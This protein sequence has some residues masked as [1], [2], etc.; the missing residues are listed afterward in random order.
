MHYYVY[1]HSRQT[2][3]TP[4]YVGMGSYGRAYE[5]SGSRRNFIWHRINKKHGT[6][7]D[8][9]QRDMSRN[10]ALLLEMWL[11]AKFR[12]EGFRLANMTMGGEGTLGHIPSSRVPVCCSDKNNDIMCFGHAGE[13]ASYLRELGYKNVFRSNISSSASGYKR[14]AYDRVWWVD[15]DVT[16]TYT[17]K[18]ELIA[19]SHGKKIYNS[20]GIEFSR[21]SEAISWLKTVGIANPGQSSISK[22]AINEGVAYGYSWSY[23]G[24]PKKPALVGRKVGANASRL[25]K[26]IPVVS[27]RGEMFLSAADAARSMRDNG[28][29]NAGQGNISRAIAQPNR[30]AYGRK[31]FKA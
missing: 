16:K 21:C 28:Y 10:S 4:F 1:V 22:A 26:S 7:I 23:V 3:G 20:E 29:P 17:N 2:D 27:C 19:V 9:C 8:I 5:N 18:R 31:W 25:V 15:G 13:A 30:S 6:I 11:I 12:N 14:N 24:F